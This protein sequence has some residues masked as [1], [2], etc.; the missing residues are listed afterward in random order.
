MACEL[1]PVPAILGSEREIARD[2]ADPGRLDARGV[3]AGAGLRTQRSGSRS[4]KPPATRS[5]WI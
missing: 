3:D 1:L 2:W 5:R 4:W